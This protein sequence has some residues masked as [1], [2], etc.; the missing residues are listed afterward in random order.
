MT[1]KETNVVTE[2]AASA[3]INAT[4][5]I[6]YFADTS[7]DIEKLAR[8]DKDKCELLKKFIQSH[9]HATTYTF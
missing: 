7:I 4:R 3:D 2:P 8:V 5:N 9:F 1:L 6:I